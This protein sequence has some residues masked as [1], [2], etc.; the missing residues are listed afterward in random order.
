[1]PDV[2][3]SARATIT[4]KV[5]VKVRVQVDAAGNVT[6]ADFD[7]PGP[8]K[9]FARVALQAAKRWKFTPADA[10]G[11]AASREWVLRFEFG[12]SGTKVFPARVAR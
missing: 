11:Q 12:R 6:A 5:K 2:S 7:S 4:G 3:A 9:Y 1:M 8:S 10:S